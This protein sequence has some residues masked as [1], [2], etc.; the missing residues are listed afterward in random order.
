MCGG[1]SSL[2]FNIPMKQILIYVLVGSQLTSSS[3]KRGKLKAGYGGMS[4]LHFNITVKAHSNIY[5][6]AGNQLTSLSRE[7]KRVMTAR[8]RG[9]WS[10]Y[11]NI[12]V[13]PSTN[14]IWA[15]SWEPVNISIER[16]GYG[17][18]TTSPLSPINGHE[19]QCS[20]GSD[21]HPRYRELGEYYAARAC[22]GVL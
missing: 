22:A 10:S 11:S 5:A 17:D 18:T 3:Q 20:L 4:N 16:E 19:S 8:Y 1:K 2:H 9:K 21:I 12:L 7:A 14:N 15:I 6:V 13:K